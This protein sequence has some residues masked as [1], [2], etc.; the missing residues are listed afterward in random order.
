MLLDSVEFYVKSCFC[1]DSHN[2]L[3]TLKQGVPLVLKRDLTN[4]TDLHG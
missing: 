4:Q 3:S 2:V 1:L